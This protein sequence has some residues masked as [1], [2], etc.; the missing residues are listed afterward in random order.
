MIW[1]PGFEPVQPRMATEKAIADIAK[2]RQV[3]R[4]QPLFIELIVP[5]TTVAD[6]RLT[7]AVQRAA[8][9]PGFTESSKELTQPKQNWLLML[10]SGDGSL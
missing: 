5:S 8:S 9:L 6:S 7:W 3:D 10:P 2:T 1:W 4:S